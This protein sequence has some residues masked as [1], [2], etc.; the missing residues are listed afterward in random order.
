MVAMLGRWWQQIGV[1]QS[2][3]WRWLCNSGAFAKRCCWVVGVGPLVGRWRCYSIGAG[4]LVLEERDSTI[5][6]RGGRRGEGGGERATHS[7]TS[8][9]GN[10]GGP[11]ATTFLDPPMPLPPPLPPLTG[12]HW[13]RCQTKL[14]TWTWQYLRRGCRYGGRGDV[15]PS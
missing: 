3:G 10:N 8:S 13:C 14:R 15:G 6:L 5:N 11:I 7:T 12:R 4:A 9:M 1:G 2:L